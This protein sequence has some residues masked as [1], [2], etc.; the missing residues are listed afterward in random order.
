MCLALGIMLMFVGIA[1][2]VLG[3][4]KNAKVITVCSIALLIIVA[5]VYALFTYFYTQSPY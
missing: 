4:N 5:I 3:L 2:L 1:G